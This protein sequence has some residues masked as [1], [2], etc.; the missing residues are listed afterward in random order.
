MEERTLGRTGLSVTRI[1]F[2]TMTFGGQTDEAAAWRAWW[3]DV[4]SAA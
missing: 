1:C 2:G 4:S 3:T